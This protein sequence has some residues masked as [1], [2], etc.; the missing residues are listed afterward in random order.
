MCPL[1]CVSVSVY[2][3]DYWTGF[4]KYLPTI[5]STKWVN[6]MFG[7]IAY[8]YTKINFKSKELLELVWQSNKVHI[9]LCA[10]WMLSG[11]MLRTS[12][13]EFY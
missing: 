8:C 5:F 4:T 1:D 12:T 2:K 9:A 6:V 3:N 10:L 7:K 11:T 13:C